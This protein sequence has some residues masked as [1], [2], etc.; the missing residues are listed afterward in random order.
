MYFED[1]IGGNIMRKKGKKLLTF[2]VAMAM[3]LTSVWNIP[4]VVKAAQPGLAYRWTKIQNDQMIEDTTEPLN[5]NLSGACFTYG[6][7]VFFYFVDVNGNETRLDASQLRSSDSSVVEVRQNAQYP[8]VVELVYTGIG[9]ADIIYKHTD[10]NEYTLPIKDV[11]YPE[12]ALYST[13]TPSVSGNLNEFTVTET[14]DTFYLVARTGFTVSNVSVNSPSLTTVTLMNGGQYA[15]IKV[16]EPSHDNWL[17]VNFDV[18]D[19]TTTLTNWNDGI[20]IKDGRPD[21]EFA[22]GHMDNGNLTEESQGDTFKNWTTHPGN[23]AFMFFYYVE[24]N[25][26]TA[27]DPGLLSTSNSNVVTIKRNEQNPNAATLEAIGFGNATINY[28]VNGKTYSMEVESRLPDIGFYSAPQANTANYIYDFAVTSTLNT[29]YLIGANGWVIQSA[30]LDSDFEEI[31]DLAFDSN[32]NTG[33]ITINGNPRGDRWYSVEC[34]AD[35]GIHNEMISASIRVVDDRPNLK[36]RWAEWQNDT[37][38]ENSNMELSDRWETSPMY[39]A[40]VFFYQVEGG[41]SAFVAPENLE[42]SDETVV[43]VEKNP[44][45]SNAAFLK[46]VGFG[47]ATIDYKDPVTGTVY[48]MEVVVDLPE[49][50]VFSQPVFDQSTYLS[51]FTVTDTDDTFYI[52]ADTTEWQMQ[53]VRLVNGLENIATLSFNSGDSYATVQVTGIPD[54]GCWYNVDV[55]VLNLNDGRRDLHGANVILYNGLPAQPNYDWTQWVEVFPTEGVGLP[56]HI[57]YTDGFGVVGIANV[58]DIQVTGKDVNA[59]QVVKEIMDDGSVNW[60]VEGKEI[61]TAELTITHEDYTNPSNVVTYTFDV[62]VIKHRIGHGHRMMEGYEQVAFPGETSKKALYVSYDYYDEDLGGVICK[63]ITNDPNTTYS[64][65]YSGISNQSAFVTDYNNNNTNVGT[66]NINNSAQVGSDWIHY[67]CDIY[68]DVNGER[69]WSAFEDTLEVVETYPVITAPAL[70]NDVKVGMTVD[71]TPKFEFAIYDVT[72]GS[73]SY[74]LIENNGYEIY[75]EWHTVVD[76]NELPIFCDGIPVSYRTIVRYDSQAEYT[77]TRGFVFDQIDEAFWIDVF[78]M[79]PNTGEE[80]F[81]GQ[82][83]WGLNQTDC[84][85][86]SDEIQ[87]IDSLDP[88]CDTDGYTGD[89][90]CPFCDAIVNTGTVISATGH[91]HISLVIPATCTVDGEKIYECDCGDTYTEVLSAIGHI[92]SEG[93][94]TVCQAVDADYQPATEVEVVP[95]QEAEKAATDSVNT[96]TNIVS[97]T[98]EEAKVEAE[99]NGETL[100]TQALVEVVKEAL[101][102]SDNNEAKA[103]VNSVSEETL[104]K[105]IVALEEEK[106]IIATVVVQPVSEEEMSESA[107]E[108]VEKI[109]ALAGEDSVVAQYLDLYV[110]IQAED[111]T[112][113]VETLG[114]VDEPTE[115]FTFT[116]SIP[117]NLQKEG[118]TFY[119][120]RVHA[121]GEAERIEVIDNND[122]TLS[123]KTDKFS[124]YAL[125]YADEEVTSDDSTDDNPGGNEGADSGSGSA[126]PEEGGEKDEAGDKEV[127]DTEEEADTDKNETDELEKEQGT[128]TPSTGDTGRNVWMY[129]ILTLGAMIVLGTSVSKRKEE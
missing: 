129:M 63:D 27:V 108:D 124:T 37:I 113:A 19:G 89:E 15:E 56:P 44:R 16:T 93:K 120:I 74:D 115:E 55:D 97:S 95:S 59:V 125:A 69:L 34:V 86:P 90:Y 31:A 48:S 24:G 53:D 128:T 77:M 2:L 47:N 52:M 45:N 39:D 119:V 61:G 6:S 29:F 81:V 82:Y 18:F 50:G 60:I 25:V 21:L 106:E 111:S 38:V 76:D 10:G 75:M 72:T 11:T 28:T 127:E 88:T 117:E 79:N 78:A 30:S 114:T 49:A 110:L 35:N 87:I 91:S 84:P 105:V 4:T 1:D 126:A 13:T 65:Y 54:S 67:G 22:W 104:E 118:R 8:D 70:P 71:V 40:H 17:E 62:E 14:D 20:T 5:D 43:T 41:N 64:W 42:S 7:P 9:N 94:C 3:V 58:L 32:T 73:V 101:E 57:E 83:H 109:E 102:N 103:V 68:Y 107:K 92:Y 66:I 100:S 23:N 116:L 98:I 80:F 123:F 122:G 96:I 99:M 26:E 85:H 121:N 46:A 112:G 36:F 51:E 12:V 33:T